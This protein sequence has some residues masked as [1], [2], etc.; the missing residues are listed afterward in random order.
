MIPPSR[1]TTEKERLILLHKCGILDT[2]PEASFDGL[3]ELAAAITNTPVALISLIDRDRQ[4]FKARHGLDAT[5]IPRELAF[6]AHAITSPDEVL[7]VE[8][9]QKDPRFQ[10]N[11]LIE[12]IPRIVFYAGVPLKVGPKKLPLGTLC[13]IDHQPRTLSPLVLRQLKLL[14]QQTESLLESRLTH[15]S[16]KHAPT[17]PKQPDGEEKILT[18]IAAQVP[19]MVYQYRVAP[20]GTSHFPYCSAGIQ[21][22]YGITPEQAA[23]DALPVIE[24]LHPDDSARVLASIAESA[25]SLSLWACEYR[26]Q[27]PNGQTLWLHGNAAPERLEDGSTLWHGFITDITNRKRDEALLE[28]QEARF[29]LL[30]E[31]ITDYAVYLLDPEGVVASWNPGAHRIK[32]YTSEEIIGQHFSRFFRDED[33]RAGQCENVLKDARETGHHEE[34]G[35]RTRKDGTLIWAHCLVTPTFSKDGTLSGY[36]KIVRDITGQRKAHERTALLEAIVNSASVAIIAGTPTGIITAFNPAAERMLGYEASELVDKQ[37]PSIFHDPTEVVERAAELTKELG[38]LVEPG[39][40][41]FVSKPALLDIPDEREWTYIRKDGSRFPVRLCVTAIRNADKSI[42]GFLGLATD[43][44]ELKQRETLNQQQSEW[45]RLANNTAGI[46]LWIYDTASQSL[47]WDDQMHEIYALPVSEFKGE[48]AD[49][50][51]RLHPE[52][53]EYAETELSQSMVSGTPFRAK[54]RLL[55]PDNS[56]RHI[57]ASGGLIKDSRGHTVSMIGVNLD[58]T[59]QVTREE[60]LQKTLRALEISNQA[61]LDAKS[62]AEAASRAKS[63]FLATMS[64]EIRTP[65]NGVLGFTDLLLETPLTDLQRQYISTIKG[66]GESLLIIINDI[67]DLSKIEAGKLTLDFQPFDLHHTI[68][69]ICNLLSSRANEKGLLLDFAYPDSLPKHIHSD[70]QRMRQILLNLTGNALKFTNSGSVQVRVT[71]VTVARQ[72]MA[73]IEVTDTGI[74]LNPE[75][76]NRL[77]QNFSQADSSTTRRFGGTGLGLVITKRLVELM[78][79]EIGLESQVGK[80]STFWFTFPLT[81]SVPAASP[82]QTI[83]PTP[84]PANTTHLDMRI[85]V[86]EDNATNQMFVAALLKKLGCQADF[87][88]TGLESV[89]CFEDHAYSAILMDCHMPEMDGYDAT[90]EIR[91][92]EKLRGGTARTPIIALTASVMQEDRD[93]C[94]AVGMDAFLTKPLRKHELQSVLEQWVRAKNTD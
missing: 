75:Q 33:R 5:E 44:T 62:G 42:A 58:I 20:D 60:N 21:S 54:Y 94:T 70:E 71:E 2:A 26:Y 39:F 47:K 80:G 82:T 35:W 85:L 13:V 38:I 65:M 57:S 93:R 86:A 76:Q 29:R 49:W 15:R 74:G 14:A 48:Y 45:M 8:D 92:L 40:G 17:V 10:G 84:S 25:A 16:I 27:H 64:H 81:E 9:S 59:D 79:G 69:D 37:S 52:D 73:R 66:S 56:V 53:R 11:P 91:R 22:I 88:A 3:V 50:R 7:I 1:T 19:G 61:A 4:W 31:G 23:V 24:R 18:K 6:C 89:R 41:A 77:F 90:L 51:D 32:G 28:R 43:I 83:R 78:G 67:L 36:T 30:V 87:A 72:R 55:L 63:E 34:N 12:G 68:R 46:G